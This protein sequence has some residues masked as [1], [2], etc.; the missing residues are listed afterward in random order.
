MVDRL[1]TLS[2]LSLE[3][4]TILHVALE[5]L[6]PPTAIQMQLRLSGS[7]VKADKRVL[8]MQMLGYMGTHVVVFQNI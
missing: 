4:K 7:I 6:V 1:L 8:S 3:G 5:E 2:M